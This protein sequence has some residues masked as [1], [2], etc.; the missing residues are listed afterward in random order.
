MK[1]ANLRRPRLARI[2]AA[3]LST[4]ALAATAA[5]GFCDLNTPRPTVSVRDVSV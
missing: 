4:L 2:A 1:L 5:C 3:V